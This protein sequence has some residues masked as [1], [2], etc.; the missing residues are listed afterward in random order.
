MVMENWAEVEAVM[1]T[2]C[3][4]LGNPVNKFWSLRNHQNRAE[5]EK[6]Q[7][8]H[9]SKALGKGRWTR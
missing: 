5:R 2:I 8:W 1:Q 3:S 4:C 7:L 9:D 6:L